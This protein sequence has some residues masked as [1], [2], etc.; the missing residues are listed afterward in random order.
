MFLGRVPRTGIQ[1][2]AQWRFFAGLDATGAP[3]WLPSLAARQPV[4][5]DS[6]RVYSRLQGA[7]GVR[8]LSVL[9]QGSVVFNRPLQRY[10]YTSWTE[11][12][13][14]FYEAPR[15]WGPWRRFLSKDFGGYPWRTNHYG[16]YATTIPSR[17]ISL[18]GRSMYVQCNTFVGG[19]EDYGFSLRKL[20]VVPFQA[21]AA[22]TDSNQ[23]RNLA[24]EPGTVPISKSTRNGRIELMHDG[25]RDTSEDDWDREQKGA[26]WWGY[27]WPRSYRFDRVMLVTGPRRADGGWFAESPRVQVRQNFR[28][29]D[30]TDAACVPPYAS[31]PEPGT[32]FTFQFAP[33]VGDGVRI[34]GTPAGAKAFTSV[35]E[36]S[37]Y[38]GR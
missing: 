25:S 23:R 21:S 27:T 31:P 24:A 16:G 37:V 29:V 34:V 28:W 33:V 26:S 17:F 8:N 18:D 9:G 4:L 6:R 36:L 35:A 12:T 2:R 15:P 10:L 11:Y 19:V 13:F 30:V 3:M 32:S 14:E 1:D 38:Y 7:K 20:R 5:E 22:V